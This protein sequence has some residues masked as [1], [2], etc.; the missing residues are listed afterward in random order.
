[1]QSE[2]S[3]YLAGAV[4]TT[5]I[6]LGVFIIFTHSKD[7]NYNYINAKEVSALRPVWSSVSPPLPPQCVSAALSTTPPPVVPQSRN[8]ESLNQLLSSTEL[9]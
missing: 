5:P 9:N 4:L 3:T 6:A 8:S 2:S 7:C 1:M